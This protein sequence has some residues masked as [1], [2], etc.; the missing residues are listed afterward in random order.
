MSLDDCTNPNSVFSLAELERSQLTARE[1]IV[2]R[3]FDLVRR[4][5]HV[6]V[7]TMDR[8]ERHSDQDLYAGLRQRGGAIT[9]NEGYWAAYRR[10]RVGSNSGNE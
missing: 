1:S 8:C 2:V 7:M 3:H 9:S 5:A 10:A 4:M 6:T